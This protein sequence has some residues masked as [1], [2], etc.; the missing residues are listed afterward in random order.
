MLLRNL[1]SSDRGSGSRSTQARTSMQEAM[2][3]GD[4]RRQGE[5]CNDHGNDVV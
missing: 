1:S 3:S 5:R 4:T 2:Q